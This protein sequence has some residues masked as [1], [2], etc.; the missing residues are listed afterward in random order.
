VK[1]L[2]LKAK[3]WLLLLLENVDDGVSMMIMMMMMMTKMVI[4]T[5]KAWLQD[6]SNQ[7]KQ[8]QSVDCT[9]THT[10]LLFTIVGFIAHL[11]ESSAVVACLYLVVTWWRARSKSC[12]SLLFIFRSFSDLIIKSQDIRFRLN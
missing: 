5:I 10:L 7:H 4:V 6:K 9:V 11:F 1:T 12:N 3:S 2:C 8:L